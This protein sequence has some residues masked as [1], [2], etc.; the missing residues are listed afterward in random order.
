VLSVRIR[1]PLGF[2]RVFERR[3][4]PLR[5]G[6]NGKDRQAE[7]LAQNHWEQWI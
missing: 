3:E 1:L 7:R 4:R 2:D 5:N 6:K